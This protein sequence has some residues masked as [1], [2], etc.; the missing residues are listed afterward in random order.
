MRLTTGRPAR[1]R[2]LTGRPARMRP[3]YRKPARVRQACKRPNY[4]EA[5]GVG[6]IA[7]FGETIRK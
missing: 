5:R 4:T 1:L 2:P 6:Q 7:D 3:L